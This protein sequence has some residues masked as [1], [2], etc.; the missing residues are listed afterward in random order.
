MPR[1]H[2]P[3][4][5]RTMATAVFLAVGTA[6]AAASPTELLLKPDELS[7]GA[8]SK[9]T[10]TKREHRDKD[11]REGKLPK[12][13]YYLDE[14]DPD[15]LI[16]RRQDG[17]FVATFSAGGVSR[18]SIVEAAKEDYRQLVEADAAWQD[19]EEEEEDTEEG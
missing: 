6:L 8:R 15:I 7:S 10:P 17:S 9:P 2:L 18:E 16:L 19:Q 4:P 1:A 12:F 11:K 3:V 14:S 13:D 5:L